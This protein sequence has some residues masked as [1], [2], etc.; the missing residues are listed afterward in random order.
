M[1]KKCAKKRNITSIYASIFIS[2]IQNVI[3]N[4]R[5]LQQYFSNN[6]LKQFSDW[7]VFVFRFCTYTI[8]IGEALLQT[9]NTVIV[10]FLSYKTLLW[11]K[12]L[13]YLFAG[14]CKSKSHSNKN[15]CNVTNKYVVLLFVFCEYC[16]ISCCE[17]SNICTEYLYSILC[18]I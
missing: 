16:C 2:F 7:N 10:R 13:F 15:M 8:A 6:D 4:F 18:F 11:E 14:T 17:K 9:Q 5:T 12:I 1:L 3:Y